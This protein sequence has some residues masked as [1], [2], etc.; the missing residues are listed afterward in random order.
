MRLLR[1]LLALAAVALV[2]IAGVRLSPVVPLLVDPILV[3]I[4]YHSLVSPRG[5]DIVGASVAGLVHDALT[6]GVYG[7]LGLVDT[8]TAYVCSR[9]RRHLVLL[10]SWRLGLFFSLLA[11]LQQML[12]AAVRFLLLDGVEM[13]PWWSVA[14]KMVT[15]GVLGALA[16]IIGGG[17]ARRAKRRHTEHRRKPTLDT[18]R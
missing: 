5:W 13:M 16:F 8:I 10:R 7:Q 1:F 17:L 6:G 18:S 14:A 15:T 9:S 11:L 2:H 12:L 3:L 4:L